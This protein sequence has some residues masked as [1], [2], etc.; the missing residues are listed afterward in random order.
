MEMT[1]KERLIEFLKSAEIEYTEDASP[2][3][4]WHSIITYYVEYVFDNKGEY[5][6]S[7]NTYNG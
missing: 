3:N 5:Q 2:K 6:Y 4:T 7:S 1:S